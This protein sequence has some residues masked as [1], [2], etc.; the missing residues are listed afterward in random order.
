[1]GLWKVEKSRKSLL[2]W[3]GV[4]LVVAIL[5]RTG[6]WMAYPL[7]ESNDTPTYRHLSR[8]LGNHG[9][10]NYNGTRTPGYPLFLLITASDAALY[11]V[12]LVL[13]VFTT[14]L[15]FYIVWK[16]TYRAWF[17]GALALAHTLNL[18]QLFFEASV[19]SE[20]LATFLLF[21][22]LAGLAWFW[23]QTFPDA[24]NT[25]S[26]DFAI[27]MGIAPLIGLAAAALAM[28][29][30]L[31][32]PVAF[33]GAFFLA[34]FSCVR[35]GG[36]TGSWKTR[37][38]AAILVALPVAIVL[39]L[40]VNFIHT[41]FKIWGLDSMGGYH[42]VNHTSSFFELAPNEY[43]PVRDTFLQFRAIR[44]AETGSPVNTIWDAIPALMEQEKLNYYA[45]GRRMGEISQRLIAEHPDLYAQNL[46]R[47]WWW[48]WRVGVFW[49][50][51]AVANPVLRPVL[52]ALMF[53]ERLGLFGVNM[54][55]LGG[56][57]S[58]LWDK[59]RAR[60]QPPLFIWFAASAIWITSVLQTL[61]EHGDNPRFL[62]P[63][64]TLVVLVVAWAL[65]RLVDILK[66][67]T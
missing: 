6:L 43:A 42:L 30:P 33:L 52:S 4:V 55:F 53:A 1:M 46:L 17:A 61:A 41:R 15:V 44:M 11:A 54:L 45:L 60:L 65:V 48:F 24:K 58:L 25:K 29:R 14:L 40:W 31:F 66:S 21:C 22:V 8:S 50:P 20:S 56:S 47:G 34:F 57:V 18:G 9:F 19:L 2:Q 7:A 13:G 49:L 23:G 59:V 26:P 39:G 5:V 37:W 36:R 28:T 32:A 51:D 3:L 63:M 35:Q 38:G 62:A 12:Q 27:Q 16:L 64:Q 10:D 67:K